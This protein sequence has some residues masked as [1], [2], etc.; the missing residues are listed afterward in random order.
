MSKSKLTVKQEKFTLNLFS[1]M[2]ESKAYAG[3]GYAQ[4]SPA[5]ISANACRLAKN[6]NVLARL[7]ELREKAASA[8]IMNVIERREKLSEIAREKLYTKGTILRTG[9]LQAVEIL[10]K[11]DKLYSD[12]A[13]VNIDNRSLTI[14]VVSEHARKLTEQIVEG[15]G[16]ELATTNH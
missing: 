7:E 1:G 3:A 10:N 4:N 2:N 13:Q 6:V 9:N 15:K 14:N 5:T 8:K 11:M 12:G 16:T